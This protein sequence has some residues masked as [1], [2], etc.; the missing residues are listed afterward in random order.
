MKRIQAL[1]SVFLTA[2]MLAGIVVYGG[3]PVSAAG[4]PSGEETTVIPAVRTGDSSEENNS[5]KT[6]DTGPL[7]KFTVSAK[8]MNLRKEP[9]METSTV[10]KLE[11][12]N[13]VEVLE[14]GC[15]GF[16]RATFEGQEGYV[17]PSCVQ[18]EEG[19]KSPDAVGSITVISDLMT[20]PVRS[21]P[22]ST[23]SIL[24]RIPINELTY[25][26]DMTDDGWY[27]MR[28][29]GGFGYVSKGNT[30]VR[31]VDD[32]SLLMAQGRD[33]FYGMDAGGY[34]KKQA[35]T[36]FDKAAAAGSADAWT[37]L[38]WLSE[39]S[40]D[41]DRNQVALENVE[42]A[43]DAGSALGMYAK[44]EM[45]LS[46]T[47]MKQ[48]AALAKELFEGALEKGCL[49]AN[50]G[51]GELYQYGTGV[52]EDGNKA[53]EYY[54]K[55]LAGTDFETVNHARCCLGRLYQNGAGGVGADIK[56]A[57][58]YFKDAADEGYASALYE[59]GAMY[60]S[61][62]LGEPDYKK[63]VSLFEKAAKAGDGKASWQLGSMY[64]NAV[65]VKQDAAKAKEYF[66]QAAGRGEE[67]AFY[68]LA[69]QYANG[70]GTKT[71]AES[72]VKWFKKASYT[73]DAWAMAWLGYMTLEGSG[74]EQ[75]TEES[76]KWFKK[77]VQNGSGDE[78]LMAYVAEELEYMVKNRYIDQK[79][80]DSVLKG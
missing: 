17:L 14:F 6:S 33:Y 51:L 76:L 72:A 16:W 32:V 47:G 44:G 52:G 30:E 7:G 69:Y 75:S 77:A 43:I 25:Y 78:E 59:L 53:R 34:N 49:L 39:K 37:Y 67:A 21:I 40:A 1:I 28:Y 65:G 18:P 64:F 41:N 55:A 57:E 79:T 2:A 58:T 62:A 3:S 61:G 11:K 13:T 70:I 68:P 46:G 36:C 31:G 50:C 10:A 63:A 5:A 73:G 45:A 12:G 60:Y 56:K 35:K 8:T 74:T 42:K 4:T 71:D 24:A 19:A 9:K 54:E 20:A 15:N 38:C 80:A 26:Y 23:G 22:V 29:D 27:L 48:D 66:E